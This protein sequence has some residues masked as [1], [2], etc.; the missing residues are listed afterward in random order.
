VAETSGLPLA[1]LWIHQALALERM[2][3]RRAGEKRDYYAAAV[4]NALMPERS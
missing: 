4:G 2:R 3:T 1:N